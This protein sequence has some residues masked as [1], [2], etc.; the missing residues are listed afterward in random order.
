MWKIR[1]AKFPPWSFPKVVYAECICDKT[2]SLLRLDSNPFSIGFVSSHEKP[3]K[4]TFC[5]PV[6]LCSVR[7]LSSIRKEKLRQWSNRQTTKDTLKIALHFSI[8]EIIFL[9][10]ENLWKRTIFLYP[11]KNSKIFFKKRICFQ[12]IF[13]LVY[14]LL[15]Y[16]VLFY[17]SIF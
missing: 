8:D 9:I 15:S 12:R 5:L 11:P 2:P 16:F 7:F 14:S 17:F 3:I 13:V 1:S 10:L 4:V 6:R